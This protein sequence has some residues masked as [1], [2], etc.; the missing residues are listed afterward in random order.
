MAAARKHSRFSEL[1]S[2]CV[3]I[4]CDNSDY[5]PARESNILLKIH[6]SAEMQRANVAKWRCPVCGNQSKIH[7]VRTLSEQNKHHLRLAIGAVNT[8]LYERDHGGDGDLLGIPLPVF[9]LDALPDD[10]K[11]HLPPLEGAL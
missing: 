8:A 10:W 9:C 6:D 5:C 11:P 3:E 7:Y 4:Y 2:F 1:G